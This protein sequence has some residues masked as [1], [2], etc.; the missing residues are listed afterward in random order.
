MWHFLFFGPG[1]PAD[2]YYQDFSQVDD[3][4]TIKEEIIVLSIPQVFGY[5]NLCIS[6]L[7]LLRNF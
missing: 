2:N 7:G 3:D 6:L 4:L 5:T 1:N